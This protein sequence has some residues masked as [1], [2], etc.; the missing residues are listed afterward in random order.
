[1]RRPTMD[2]VAARAG[3]SRSLVSLVMRQDPGVS[4]ARRAAVQAAAA[5]LGYTPHAMARHL[6]SRS[7]TVLAVLVSDLHNPYF[8]DIVDGI[9]SEAADAGLQTILSSGGRLAGA[10]ASAVQTLL[11]FR[12]AGLILLSPVLSTAALRVA[13]QATP[14]VAVERSVRLPGVDTVVDDGRAG[15]GLALQHL[16]ELGHRRVVH[17]DGGR[18]ASA[19]VR[20]QGYLEAAERLGLEPLVV[21]SEFTEDAGA[22]AMHAAL[23]DHPD[24]TAVAAAND[25]QAVGA[26]SALADAGAAVPQQVSVVGYDNTRLSG[27]RHLGL[28]TLDQPRQEM[29]RLAVRAVR[30]R[31]AGRVAPARHRLTPR[32]VVRS[33]TGPAPARRR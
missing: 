19:A 24:L 26:L 32:L 31:M 22:A 20:R 7:S 1:M 23:A 30:E 5:E 25:W 33:S 16:Y 4:P 8:A 13:A 2:D 18:G 27:L 12:P 10:E 15:L 11:T 28:T 9:T 6:A 29:G 14:V 17:L 3:V 21:P